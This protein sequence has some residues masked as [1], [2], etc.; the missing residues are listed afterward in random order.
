[1]KRMLINATQE[2]ELRIAL[3]NGQYLYNLD[4]E[5]TTRV[6][7]KAN[8]YKGRISRVEPSLE[9]AFVNYGAERHGFLSLKEIATEYIS[10]QADAH[11]SIKDAVKEGQEIMVQIDKEERGNKGAAL[12]TYISLAGCY[13]VLMPNNPRAGGISRRIERDDRSELKEILNSLTVPE[14]MGVIVRTAGVGKSQEELQW[15]LDTLLKQ[16]DAIKNASVNADIPSLIHQESDILTRAIRDHLREDIGEILIDEEKLFNRCKQYIER[17]RPNFASRVKLYNEP[18]P[19]FNRYQ[20]ERQIESAFQREV[21][22]PSGGAIV[23][24]NTEALVAI[25]I[26]SSRATKGED[27]EATALQTNLEAADEIARQLRMR[28]L[29]GLIV[30]DFIDMTPV[31]NQREVE[32]RLRDALADDRA[33]VQI[34]RISR[35]GLLE[36][37]RQ[38][39][40]PSLGESSK[41]MCPRCTGQGS[42]RGV[43]SLGL[44]VLRLVEE[45]ALKEQGCQIEVMLP[46]PV[47]TFLL[48]E[49]RSNIQSIEDRCQTEVMIIPAAELETPHYQ[50]KRI[51]KTELA[52]GEI[53]PSYNRSMPVAEE[54]AHVVNVQA[55]R[56]I[57][58]VEAML[59]DTPAPIRQNR[60][61]SS[62]HSAEKKTG[63]V[64]RLFSSIFSGNEAEAETKT[65]AEATT[66]QQSDTNRRPHNNQRNR[67]GG[68]RDRRGGNNQRRGN[69]NRRNPNQNRNRGPRPNTGTG[70]E[71]SAE[72]TTTGNAE[73]TANTSAAPQSTAEGTTP[74]NNNQQ[75]RS[76]NNHRRQRDRRPRDNNSGNSQGENRNAPSEN[77]SSPNENHSSPS[78]NR[79]SPNENRSSPSEN[80]SSPNENRSSHSDSGNS[81]PS[82]P[83]RS[84]GDSA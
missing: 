71:T 44:A 23:I 83:T 12:T 34:G 33:R 7:T 40:R 76:H 60:P 29:G 72:G 18:V 43:E 73:S 10:T 21:K 68:D 78:E 17:L 53:A 84:D 77:R 9:A 49:K 46:I 48:N 56:Q 22:L 75:R 37:S 47:A 2:E 41:I 6:E 13:L 25:D 50:I 8:I 67:A 65:E 52:S 28:D 45:E 31:R 81:Q 36:M 42:I 15:D 35:F 3:V 58:M 20:I 4:I 63:L 51:R 74:Q 62:A 61:Q 16:W 1:M 5:T 69:N 54:T 57:P 70:S 55:E 14:D 32:N 64:K 24:D 19:L 66:E 80:R 39:L 79:N 82:T 11:R 38:R 59:P 30:I 26:N 27:I